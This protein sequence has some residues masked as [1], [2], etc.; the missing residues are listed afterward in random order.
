MDI[1]KD[2]VFNV[3][4]NLIDEDIVAEYRRNLE[5]FADEKMPPRMLQVCHVNFSDYLNIGKLFHLTKKQK[6]DEIW[7]E[8]LHYLGMP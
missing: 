5:Y 7:Q 3:V 1:V 4:N 6:M 2:E 8:Y